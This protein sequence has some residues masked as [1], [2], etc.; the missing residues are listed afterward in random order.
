VIHAGLLE[1]GTEEEYVWGSTVVKAE[2][3]VPE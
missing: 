1:R 2:H 3:T